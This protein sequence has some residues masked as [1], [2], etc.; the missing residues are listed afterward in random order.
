[1]GKTDCG[2]ALNVVEV[3][4]RFRFDTETEDK[5]VAAGALVLSHKSFKDTY[6]GIL[7][8]R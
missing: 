8:F 5:L 1:M 7:H 6:L 2:A 3:E 4:R